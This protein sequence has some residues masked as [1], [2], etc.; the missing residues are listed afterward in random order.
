MEHGMTRVFVG[1]VV[2]GLLTA[3]RPTTDVNV[4][5]MLVQANPDGGRTPVP[6]LEGFVR[7]SAGQNRDFL[8]TGSQECDF[9]VRDTNMET[10][11]GDNEPALGYCSSHC[12][13]N[14]MCQGADGTQ[15]EC[16]A[17]LLTVETLVDTPISGVKDPYFCV[18]PG[19]RDGG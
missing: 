11:A 2:G 6:L 14:E 17:L 10:D 8:T 15:L 1:V 7:R 16:R 19:P 9:C 13:N 12:R 3:C 5:C 18:R 4:P